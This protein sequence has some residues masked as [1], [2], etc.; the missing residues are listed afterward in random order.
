MGTFVG[1]IVPGLCLVLLGVW[2]MFNTIIEYSF[3]GR[4]TFTSKF[5]YP[6]NCPFFKLLKYSELILIF[7][8]SVFAAIIQILDYPHFQFSFE[9][10]NLEHMT[11]FLHLALYS[12][13]T[14]AGELTNSPEMLSGIVG[15][16]ASSVFG[17]ELFLLHYHSADRIGLEGHYHWLLQVIVFFT[18]ISAV[19]MTSYPGSFKL[20]AL[21]SVLV[22]LQGCWF[23]NMGFMLWAPSFVPTG[24]NVNW[25]KHGNGI[26]GVVTCMTDAARVRAAAVANLQFSWIL[27]GILTFTAF[28]CLK[29]VRESRL[30]SQSTAYE[31]LRIRGVD[32]NQILVDGVDVCK[33]V[34]S[35]DTI[36][37]FSVNLSQI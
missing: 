27:G 31:Q 21:L 16:L 1:H 34:D 10:I 6:F 8:F 36:V 25:I 23:I 14:L 11:I 3:K 12:G 29:I 2:H 37:S 20:S 24:C 32:V 9:F 7:T 18:F 15:I 4:T 22:V 33:Q 28:S 13:F 35:K 19:G 26:H 17:Q 30:R 5:W